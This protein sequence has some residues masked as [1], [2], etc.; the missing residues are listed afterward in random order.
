MKTNENFILNAIAV[1]GNLALSD[2]PWRD[3]GF[4]NRPKSGTLFQKFNSDW[5]NKLNNK[6]FRIILCSSIAAHFHAKA[7]PGDSAKELILKLTENPRVVK[8][9]NF[10]NREEALET[11]WHLL[12]DFIE[13]DP[14][15]WE[16]VIKS[17]IGNMKIPNLELKNQLEKGS[18]VFGSSLLR[19][20]S[21]LNKN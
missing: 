16:N 15:N 3:F 9:M 21:I 12:F 5:K 4:K 19:L 14:S 10:K 6:I 1:S 17:N 18:V 13:I 8:S 2:E 7:I 11:L 20:V